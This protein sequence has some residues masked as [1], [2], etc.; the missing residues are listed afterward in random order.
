MSERWTDPDERERLD[1]NVLIKVLPVC[2]HF[3]RD[4]F[5]KHISIFIQIS[6][7]ENSTMISISVAVNTRSKTFLHFHF[8]LVCFFANTTQISHNE[9]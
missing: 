9:S 3:G 1:Q 8:A 6:R 4:L 5:I 2:V 7:L